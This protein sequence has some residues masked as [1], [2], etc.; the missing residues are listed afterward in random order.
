MKV[1]VCVDNFDGYED[2]I[3]A[4]VAANSE[5]E[6]ANVAREYFGD[7]LWTLYNLAEV[8]KLFANVDKPQII[9]I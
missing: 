5:E 3:A 2:V 4:L 7:F 1:F 6:A 9:W 8:P